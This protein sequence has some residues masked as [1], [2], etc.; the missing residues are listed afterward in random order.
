LVPLLAGEAQERGL[1]AALSLPDPGYRGQTLAL[2][3]PQLT[4]EVRTRALKEALAA[5]EMSYD[6]RR[7]A[8]VLALLAPQLTGEERTRALEQ[9]LEAAWNIRDWYLRARAF[10]KLAPQL[11]GELQAYALEYGLAAAQAVNGEQARGD[12]L[13]E[14]AP[15]L[16]G[17]ML[18]K[19]LSAALTIRDEVAQAT[20]LAALK[21]GLAA[22][23]TI[24]VRRDQASTW[25]RNLAVQTRDRARE[26]L[27]VGVSLDEISRQEVLLAP[28]QPGL[29]GRALRE[30]LANARRV[31]SYWNAI[32][33]R[34]WV[35]PYLTGE[36]RLQV[37]REGTGIAL[38]TR[39]ERYK[40]QALAPLA[41]QLTGETLEWAL[42]ESLKIKDEGAR[43]QALAALAPQLTGEVLGRA[44]AD[45]LTIKDEWSRAYALVALAPQLTGKPR[46]QALQEG[47]AAAQNTRNWSHRAFVLAAL[48]P[49]LTGQARTRALQDGLD[50][51]QS[52]EGEWAQAK[53]LAAFLPVAP[54]PAAILRS[55]RQRVADHLLKNLSAGARE[56]LLTFCADGR[57]F[58][59][60]LLDD[61]AL[62][63]ITDHIIEICQEWE[64]L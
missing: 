64:W 23:L 32:L 12:V 13:A 35:A 2:L 10:A 27:A 26:L 44:L 40:A 22:A 55:A 15:L 17:Q 20:A 53:A 8:S 61:S 28:R 57:L 18:G 63:A 41:P 4:G 34:A 39:Q 16:S 52:V 21:W 33:A 7:I 59:P 45:A 56:E 42:V 43:A 47:L 50:A 11:T 29:T 14:L 37:L 38:S 3:A 19:A 48:A 9:G 62:S 46:T 51:A 6:V 31:E 25:A 5:A 54:D 1:A 36:E 58:G 24:L 60:P 49:L 30:A